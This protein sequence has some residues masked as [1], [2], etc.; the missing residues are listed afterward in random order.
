MF[1]AIDKE[2]GQRFTLGDFSADLSPLEKHKL[3]CPFRG[4][5]VF[6]VISYLT[7][8][9]F[10]VRSHFRSIACVLE[11]FPEDLIYDNEYFSRDNERFYY[12]ES[13][14]HREGKAFIAD[15][16]TTNLNLSSE[17]KLIFEHKVKIPNQNKYRIADVAAIFP[18]GKIVVL[19]CQLSKLSLTEFQQRCYDYD[20]AK[21]DSL[22]F[23]GPSA[24]TQPI[25]HFLFDRH[26]HVFCL[27][28]D[29]KIHNV[30]NSQNQ[31]RAV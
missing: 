23:L 21:I 26:S 2:T 22:W 24:R 20:S 17:A 5:E 3:I 7:E 6:P 8:K 27:D 1:S 18:D 4:T 11:V 25:I 12:S 30:D 29:S 19:E 13:S 31:R 16:A 10:A 15:W 9:G 28:I 14:L